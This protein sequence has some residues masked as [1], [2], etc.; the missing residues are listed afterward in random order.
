M[1]NSI[2][3]NLI[4]F[5]S[6]LVFIFLLIKGIQIGI[7]KMFF[8]KNQKKSVIIL[9]NIFIMLIGFLGV[10]FT[11]EGILVGLNGYYGSFVLIL[12]VPILLM[13]FAMIFFSIKNLS[14]LN[15][16]ITNN[17]NKIN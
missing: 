16:K 13:F 6:L 8:D 4:I 14:K 15:K 7:K 12:E 3:Q 11:G 5:L 10:F 2:I 17:E 1:K 9:G